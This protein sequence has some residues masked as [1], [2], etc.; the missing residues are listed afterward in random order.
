MSKKKDKQRWKKMAEDAVAAVAAGGSGVSS[1][2]VGD[3]IATF[4]TPLMKDP[5]KRK[6]LDFTVDDPSWRVIKEGLKKV[7]TKKE[8]FSI[9]GDPSAWA[10]MA[11]NINIDPLVLQN[12]KSAAQGEKKFLLS[13]SDTMAS[14]VVRKKR[15]NRLQA[16]DV[17][18]GSV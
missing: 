2:G 18:N 11:E 3:N 15:L 1:N 17:G 8:A 12:L 9:S 13:N 4:P 5:A 14:M 16:N 6:M 7:D 10:G